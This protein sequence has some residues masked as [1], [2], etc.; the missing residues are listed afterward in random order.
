MNILKLSIIVIFNFC[1]SPC[2]IMAETKMPYPVFIKAGTV[3][4]NLK[5]NSAII[6]STGIYAK[7]LETNIEQR[8]LFNLYDKKGVPK[9]QLSAEGIVEIEEDFKIL[10]TFDSEKVYPPKSTLKVQNKFAQFDSQIN[11]HLDTLQISNLNSIYG[12]QTS[13]VPAARYEARTLYTTNLPL[14]FGFGLN[15]QSAYWKNDI[16]GIRLSILSLGPQF[17][18]N[19]YTEDDFNIYFFLGSEI[20]P[21]YQVSTALYSEKYSAILI[22]C[23]VESQWNS[24]LGTIQFGSHFRHHNI[25]L[26]ESNRPNLDLVPKEFS[27]DSLGFMIGYKII[28]NL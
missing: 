12:H 18:Y 7:V 2:F 1:F 13:T 27:L 28:W 24:P 3:L 8:N 23:G 15:Y 26:T 11:L 17:K 19:F 14:E 9:Y 4:T 20:A 16:E 10:P 21:I 5:D 6:L 22:D 25:A